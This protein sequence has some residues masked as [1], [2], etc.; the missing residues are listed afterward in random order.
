MN[1][2]QEKYNAYKGTHCWYCD[3]EFGK[4]RRLTLQPLVLI[5][6]TKDHIVP[7]SKGGK[8]SKN[9]IACCEDC[10]RLKGAM[11]IIRFAR[12]VGDLIETKNKGTHPMYPHF[13]TIRNRAWKIYNKISWNPLRGKS[14]F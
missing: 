13:K 2:F 1:P 14:Y 3:R 8:M 10:N 9:L 11:P 12:K 7:I 5:S 4:H 6:K